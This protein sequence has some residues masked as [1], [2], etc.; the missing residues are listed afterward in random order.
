MTPDLLRRLLILLNR[1]EQEEQNQNYKDKFYFP[2]K[3]IKETHWINFTEMRKE[4]EYECTD[5]LNSNPNTL[6]EELRRYF[7]M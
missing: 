4:I 5:I 7:F 2:R 3:I 6:D 1:L